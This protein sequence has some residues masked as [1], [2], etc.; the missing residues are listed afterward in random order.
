MIQIYKLGNLDYLDTMY[1]FHAIR[2]SESSDFYNWKASDDLIA[3]LPLDNKWA[4]ESP[5][6]TMPFFD[7][8]YKY[9]LI[10]EFEDYEDLREHFVEYTIW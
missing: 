3:T 9:N 2:K 1:M 7:E 6:S 4:G 10:Y 8:E 5:N